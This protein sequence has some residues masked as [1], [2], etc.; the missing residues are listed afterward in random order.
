MVHHSRHSFMTSDN[1]CHMKSTELELW[2]SPRG[3]NT[4]EATDETPINA[5]FDDS[6]RTTATCFNSPYL[7]L[8]GAAV[9]GIR[10]SCRIM[11]MSSR[12]A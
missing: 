3:T 4:S 11:L 9:G 7:G 6:P 10:P 12:V 8:P 1:I 2:N 5:L